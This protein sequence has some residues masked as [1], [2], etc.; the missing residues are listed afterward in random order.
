M[1]AGSSGI[2]VA[3][4]QAIYSRL[5]GRSLADLLALG[6]KNTRYAFGTYS[7]EAREHRAEDLAFDRRWGT[8][9]SGGVSVHDLGFDPSRIEHCRRYDPSNEAML[10][11]PIELLRLD[12]ADCDFIDYGAGKGRML[13]LAM[14]MEFA[15]VVGVELSR[16]LCDI[17]QANVIRFAAQHEAMPVARIVE[18]D[19]TD[20]APSGRH[21]LAYFYNPF[22][23][24]VMAGVRKK[25]EASLSNGTAQVTVIYV[26]SEHHHVFG[27]APGWTRGP[28]LKGL[29]TFFA[30]AR[31]TSDAPICR[32]NRQ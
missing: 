14:Q 28:V 32:S 16:K 19:A 25:L 13:M 20:F 8:D 24:V 2:R 1:T 15:S 18:G 12:P 9:T 30:Q 7:R 21:I 6:W 5:R 27:D 10:R 4:L 17:A 22:D 23:A 11:Q 3:M 31:Q 29:A 26:N